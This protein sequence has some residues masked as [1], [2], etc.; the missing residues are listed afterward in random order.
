M[1]EVIQR[2]Y[3]TATF[4]IDQGDDPEGWYMTAMVDVD[5]PDEVVNIVIDRLM[6]LQ[7]DDGLPVYVI[8]VRTPQRVAALLAKRGRRPRTGAAVTPSA[9][10]V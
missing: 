7:V 8:P 1:Q 6:E 9:S 3:P 5:D 2:H 4:A 10:E